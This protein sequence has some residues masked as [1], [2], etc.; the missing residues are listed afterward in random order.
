MTDHE[1]NRRSAYQKKLLNAHER[2]RH[3]V[4]VRFLKT[5]HLRILKAA[6]HHELSVAEYVR[7]AVNKE[8]SREQIQ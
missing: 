1:I 4:P 7:R 2:N 5:D 6:K 8:L 3:C